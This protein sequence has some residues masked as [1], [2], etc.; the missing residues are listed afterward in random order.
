VCRLFFYCRE[1]DLGDFNPAVMVNINLSQKG[2]DSI[3]AFIRVYKP[4]SKIK[5]IL[6]PRRISFAVENC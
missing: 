5:N 2:L 1:E 6:V 4:N 3:K